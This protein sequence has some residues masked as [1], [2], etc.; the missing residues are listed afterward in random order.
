MFNIPFLS[1][2]SLSS[3]TCLKCK[4]LPGNNVILASVRFLSSANDLTLISEKALISRWPTPQKG[5]RRSKRSDSQ[6]QR[7]SAPMCPKLPTNPRLLFCREHKHLH[8][9]ILH[10]LFIERMGLSL[11]ADKKQVYKQSMSQYQVDKSKFYKNFSEEQWRQL[12][13]NYCHGEKQ[14]LEVQLEKFKSYFKNSPQ[15]EEYLTA[16]KSKRLSNAY[17]LFAA[18]MYSGSKRKLKKREISEMWRDMPDEA[19]EKYKKIY[20]KNRLAQKDRLETIL[21]VGLN[22]EENEMLEKFSQCYYHIFK[23][24]NKIFIKNLADEINLKHAG[25]ITS[26]DDLSLV[27]QRKLSEDSVKLKELRMKIAE[28]EK[29]Y[30]FKLYSETCEQFIKIMN[31][32]HETLLNIKRFQIDSYRLMY[33]ETNKPKRVQP[34]FSYFYLSEWSKNPS[35][36]VTEAV[37]MWKILSAE[38][39]TQFSEMQKKDLEVYKK[40]MAEWKI[41]NGEELEQVNAF[42]FLG[43]YITEDG[44]S[45][46]EILARIGT[47]T[48]ALARL[49]TIWKEKQ[50]PLKPKIKLLRAVVISTALYGCEKWTLCA[51]TV[52]KLES[53]DMKCL[54]RVLR[55]SWKQKKTNEFVRNEIESKYGIVT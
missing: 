38:K 29:E 21:K 2:L 43:S 7:V 36:T 27:D 23:L 33:R 42:T 26:A 44:T 4:S 54:R 31:E 49:D 10:P 51:K 28:G 35:L 12:N 3:F 9:E 22:S 16:S 13:E 41:N 11:D 47:A 17:L 55:I 37:K 50:L 19:K 6:R 48:S 5:L 14:A 8:K 32:F 30:Y 45:T 20:Q 24:Y 40:E 46:K 1:S 25:G 52:K 15:I 53:S 39:K 18:E 34:P